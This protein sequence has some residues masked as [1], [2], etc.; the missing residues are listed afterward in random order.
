MK[1]GAVLIPPTTMLTHTTCR[2]ASTAATCAHVVTTT[3]RDRQVR[4]PHRGLHAH[5]HRRAGRRMAR[6]TRIC[7]RSPREFTPAVATR[8]DDPCCSTSPPAPPP[9]PS[10]CC[11]RRALP[12]R[13]SVH[14]V[15]DRPEARRRAAGTSPRRAGP[16]T[17]GAASSRPGSPKPPCSSTTTR[18]STRA[19][20]L[21]A[22]ARRGDDVVR[23]ADG[24][25]HAD[26]GD[27]AP[28]AAALREIVS[29]Q[30][31]RSTRRSS[32]A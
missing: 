25:A 23:A 14:H 31:S 15:L 7:R 10:W 5:R 22:L 11:T 1:L 3:G 21:D 30:A 18:A 2:T 9:N 17:R 16:S 4:R 24:V 6:T 27:L 28:P 13:P 29:A 12:R 19:A 26:P 20:L 32:P 8:A